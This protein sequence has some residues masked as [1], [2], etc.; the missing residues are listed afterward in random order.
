MKV[1]IPAPCG[2]T[3]LG[4]ILPPNKHHNSKLISTG[5]LR[6]PFRA[7]S[8]RADVPQGFATL[9]PGLCCAAPSALTEAF[10]G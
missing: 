1:S 5:I 2:N 10:S 7:H 8:Q 6:R 9:H 3:A 4:S